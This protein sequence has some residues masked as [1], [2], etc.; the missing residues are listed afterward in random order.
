MKDMVKVKPA[1]MTGG[2]AGGTGRLEKSAAAP[3]KG[4]MKASLRK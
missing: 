4:A 1:K 3:A 2:A